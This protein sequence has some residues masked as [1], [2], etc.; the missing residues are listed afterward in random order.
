MRHRQQGGAII[1]KINGNRHVATAD[2]DKYADYRVRQKPVRL[3]HHM[4]VCWYDCVLVC[5]VQTSMQTNHAAVMLH[6]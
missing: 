4:T 1:R 3:L 2:H 5:S 6:A